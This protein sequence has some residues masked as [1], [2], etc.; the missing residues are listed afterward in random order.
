MTAAAETIGRG[1]SQ[2]TI[3]PMFLGAGKHA[4]EDLPLLVEDLRK[5]H[6][7]ISFMLQPPVGEDP[8]VL[9]L[10]ALIALEQGGAS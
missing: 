7:G 4:R 1:A 10:L 8:R 3:V 2:V 5:H 9:D 6:A